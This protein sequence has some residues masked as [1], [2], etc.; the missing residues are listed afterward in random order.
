MTMR[1]GLTTRRMLVRSPVRQDLLDP[2]EAV[3]EASARPEHLVARHRDVGHPRQDRADHAVEPATGGED[4]LHV[5][6]QDVG[7]AQQADG[8]GGGRAVDHQGVPVTGLGEGLDVAE[9]EHLV[10]ARDD[11]QLLGLDGVH[12]GPVEH[13]DQPALDVVPRLLH[14]GLGVELQAA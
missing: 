12:P 2:V 4:P 5:P 9:R 6:R 7:Q 13:V 14:A 1:S 3:V 8:L 11:G 10:E